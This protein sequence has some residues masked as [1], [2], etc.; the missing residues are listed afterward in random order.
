MKFFLMLNYVI[1]TVIIMLESVYVAFYLCIGTPACWFMRP[2]KLSKQQ[3]SFL[4]ANSPSAGQEISRLLGNPKVH[5]SLLNYI[6]S[7]HT[8]LSYSFKLHFSIIFPLRFRFSI[9]KSVSLFLIPGCADQNAC[10]VWGAANV[11]SLNTGISGSNPFRIMNVRLYFSVVLTS[12]ERVFA[13]GHYRLLGV[14][15]DVS[16][17]LGSGF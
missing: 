8:L 7:A 9:Y 14:Y 15:S 2:T 11:S 16:K 13:V 12:V 4:E 10:K 3:I 5:Y 6:N 1:Y 17:H